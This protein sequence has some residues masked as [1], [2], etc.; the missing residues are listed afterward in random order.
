MRLDSWVMELF[1]LPLVYLVMR[2]ARIVYGR[3]R[4]SIFFWGSILWTGTIENLAV[5][6]G[7]YDY[8]AYANYYSFGGRV[9]QG[10]GGWVAWILFVP[11]SICLG[12]FFLS[13]PALMVSIRLL[14]DRANIWL[15]AAFAGL[16]LVSYDVFFDPLAVVNQWWRW[17]T[18]ALYI[19]GVPLSNWIGWFFLLFF[20][21]ALYE[22]TVLQQKGVRGLVWL[23]RML[24]RADTT[25]LSGMDT[26]RI[27]RIFYFRLAAYLP[28]FF[29][30]SM[31]ASLLTTTLWNNRWGPYHNVFPATAIHEKYTIPAAGQAGSPRQEPAIL[32]VGE[33]PSGADR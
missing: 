27:G 15:K 23:E 4:A 7:A 19:R 10:Y 13:F 17:T 32:S 33:Q 14:G 24:F 5:M 25:D 16:I 21:G 9:I 6:L 8:F 12:W 18:P 30:V 1:F 11:V 31:I 22:R 2:E 3:E 29:A 28:V 20:F 26:W